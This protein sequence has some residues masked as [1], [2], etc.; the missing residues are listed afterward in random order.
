M[1]SYIGWS[2]QTLLYIYIPGSV[3]KLIDKFVPKGPTFPSK[4]NMPDL[5]NKNTHFMGKKSAKVILSSYIKYYNKKEHF[6][7]CFFKGIH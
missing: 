1:D 6:K 4:C 5:E 2:L 3:L 7:L